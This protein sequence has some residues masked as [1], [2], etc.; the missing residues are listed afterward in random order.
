MV[1]G[2]ADGKVKLGM[3][4]TNKTYNMYSHP[5]S[6][7]VV[8]VAASSGGNA[9]ISGHVDGSI[10]RFTFPE[11]EG[12]QGLGHSKLLQHS[13]TPYAMAWGESI[14]IAGNDNKVCLCSY[15]SMRCLR[16]DREDGDCMQ[17]HWIAVQDQQKSSI[18][19]TRVIITATSSTTGFAVTG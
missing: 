6:S 11:Q 5:E 1:F 18:F 3:L 8:S 19:N 12:G 15:S 14:C 17:Y 10:Y 13:C 4:K 16:K 7:Y 9:I 2:L